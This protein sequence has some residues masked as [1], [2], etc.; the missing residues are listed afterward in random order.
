MKEN[1][2]YKTLI[3]Q[4][5]KTKIIGY[6]DEVGRGA[7]FGELV[8]CCI[9][10]EKSFFNGDIN[11]S[12]KLSGKQRKLLEG[13]IKENVEYSFGVVRVDEINR[14]NL[15]RA[16]ELAM[17]RA[18]EGLSKKLEILFLDGNKKINYP[19]KQI[20]VVKG[21]SEIYG[22]ACA[23]IL[24]KEYRDRMICEYDKDYPE[25][26]LSGHKGYLTKVH[27]EAIQKHG[28]TIFH[29]NYNLK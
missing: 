13:I 17:I 24:A 10:I 14:M 12:K 1:I 4:W 15:D 26:G 23:S 25:Y 21:D 6:V 18:I 5:S 8:A 27:K 22:I 9:I 20:A 19:V 28:L 3:A 2:K 16:N 29:R 7:M 11:D